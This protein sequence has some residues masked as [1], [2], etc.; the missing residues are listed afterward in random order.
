MADER[1][2]LSADV[3]RGVERQMAEE[4]LHVRVEQAPR[5]GNA[6]TLRCIAA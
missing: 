3:I 2:L 5:N 4:R 1:T 6:G